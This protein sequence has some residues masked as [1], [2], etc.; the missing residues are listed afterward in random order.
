MPWWKRVDQLALHPKRACLIEEVAHLRGHIA[1]AGRRAEDDRIVVLELPGLGNRGRLP[2]LHAGPL[3]RLFGN[4]L[5]DPLD[6]DLDARDLSRALGNR[7]GHA[8]D[9]AV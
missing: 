7:L 6:R 2:Q 9:V 3:G 5:R 4:Q 1:E 8:F